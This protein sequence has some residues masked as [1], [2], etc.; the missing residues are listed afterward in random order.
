MSALTDADIIYEDNHL[1][2]VNKK[3]GE[4]VQGDKTGDVPL[5]ELLKQYLKVKFNKPGEVFAGVIHRKYFFI[6]TV[7]IRSKINSPLLLPPLEIVFRNFV[8]RIQ[9][10]VRWIQKSDFRILIS[11]SLA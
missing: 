8:W 2:A 10:Y 1:I 7:D 5:S 9:Y 6:R 3:P 11:N 4:I